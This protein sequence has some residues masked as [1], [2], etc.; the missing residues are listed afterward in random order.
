VSQRQ[1]TSTFIAGPYK[2][3]LTRFAF[4]RRT[5]AGYLDDVYELLVSSSVSYSPLQ[6]VGTDEE[7][8]RRFEEKKLEV[9]REVAKLALGL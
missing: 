2:V 6:F 8:Q 3:M 7:A 5:A 4:P 9:V 1:T